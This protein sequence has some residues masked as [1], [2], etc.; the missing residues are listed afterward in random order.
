MTIRKHAEFWFS[1]FFCAYIRIIIFSFSFD[2]CCVDISQAFQILGGKVEEVFDY[3]LPTG[4]GRTLILIR[5]VS[6]TPEKYPRNK[7]Q[8][9][10][11]KL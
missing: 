9:K 10:K 5:K 6:E 2:P 11:K 8:M 3:E 4:D 7:G 1:V